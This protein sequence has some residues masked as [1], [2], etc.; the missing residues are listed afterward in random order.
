[1]LMSAKIRLPAWTSKLYNKTTKVTNSNLWHVIYMYYILCF[2]TIHTC[3]S[4]K[5]AIHTNDSHSIFNYV[6]LL[7]FVPKCYPQQLLPKI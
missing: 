3:C 1:M 2:L 5:E 4:Y 7:S 6:N